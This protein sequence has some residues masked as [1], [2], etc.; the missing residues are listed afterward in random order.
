MVE[1]TVHSVH[2]ISLH[3]L[4]ITTSVSFFFL[5]LSSIINYIS[6]HFDKFI[7]SSYITKK[8][9]QTPQSIS[10]QEYAVSEIEL[11]HPLVGIMAPLQGHCMLEELFHF[12]DDLKPINRIEVVDV[13]ILIIL[14]VFIKLQNILNILF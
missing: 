10:Y 13:Y 9:K 1:Y 11:L 8:T 7:F 6:S 12:Y 5:S 4:S 14:T 2:C 3:F